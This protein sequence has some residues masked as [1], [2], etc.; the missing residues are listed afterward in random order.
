MLPFV[1]YPEYLNFIPTAGLWPLIFAPDM[2]S[3][4]SAW[5][6]PSYQTKDWLFKTAFCFTLGNAVAQ[7]PHGPFQK[8]AVLLLDRT[9]GC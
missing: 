8:H 3:W 6:T 2:D 9:Y 7:L 4:L 5:L 1:L